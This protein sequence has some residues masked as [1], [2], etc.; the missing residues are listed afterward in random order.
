MEE[1]VVE[2]LEKEFNYVFKK[3]KN[4]SFFVCQ[5]QKCGE[6]YSV[7][8]AFMM[9]NRC[10]KVISKNIFLIYIERLSFIVV[11]PNT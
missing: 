2:Y 10:H 6:R 4:K 5:N 3:N 7:E 11:K 1:T 8:E 9:K